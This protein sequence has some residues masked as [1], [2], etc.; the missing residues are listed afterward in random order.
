MKEKRNK[1]NSYPQKKTKNKTVTQAKTKM[2]KIYF[3]VF[4]SLY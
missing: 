4:R 1:K 2:Y 3:E